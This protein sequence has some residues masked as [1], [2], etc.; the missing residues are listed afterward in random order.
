M[1]GDNLALLKTEDDP[2]NAWGGS[3][4]ASG[5]DY[6][7][8][9]EPETL[10]QK[11]VQKIRQWRVERMALD[12]RARLNWFTYYSLDNGRAAWQDN[13]YP[14]G[15]LGEKV[16]LRSGLVRNL[17]QHV[18]V[19][20][21]S[22]K[23]SIIPQAKNSDS[24]STKQVT[25]GKSIG[26][27]VMESYGG[28]AAANKATEYAEVLDQGFVEGEWDYEAGDVYAIGD[29]GEQVHEG[30]HRF[31]VLSPLDLFFDLAQVSWDDHSY[32]GVRKWRNRFDLIAKYC[33]GVAL[34]EVGPLADLKTALLHAPRKVFAE[35]TRVY[36]LP[37]PVQ[38]ESADTE[39]VEVFTF[40][41]KRSPAMPHGRR[42]VFLSTGQ[43]LEDGPLMEQK[44]PVWPVFPP[45]VI[46]TS[47]SFS[48]VTSLGSVQEAFNKMISM[49]ATTLFTHGVSNIGVAKGAN[50]DAT[51]VGGGQR[52]YE[53]DVGPGQGIKD[54]LAPIQ[55]T[56]LPK[57]VLEFAQIL[58]GIAEQ[59]AGLNK[60]VRGDPGGITAGVALSLYQAM[61]QQF[62][63]PLEDGRAEL[64]K[65]MVLWSW[66]ALRVYS[67]DMRRWVQVV[68]R[69]K[70]EALEKYFGSDMEG[71]DRLTVDLGNP[72]SRTAPG[73]VQ[74]IQM[75][76]QDGQ[77]L[78][79]QT[80]MDVLNTGTTDVAEEPD[81]E[82]M[83]LIRE[84]NA[85]LLD[86]LEPNVCL[87]QDDA[88]HIFHHVQMSFSTDLKSPKAMMRK[89]AT[90]AHL[91]AHLVKMSQGDLILLARRGMMQQGFAH[92]MFDHG[93]SP[94][95]PGGQKPPPPKG[96]AGVPDALRE[97]GRPAPN[98]VEPQPLSGPSPQQ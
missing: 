80:I 60:V 95:G 14:E 70:R 78:P 79:P 75:L 64:I 2:A 71:L 58:N 1:P 92:P 56:D 76:K 12:A 36:E 88:L 30:R 46:G 11:L 89:N 16:R 44:I 10:A 40:Y 45:N 33:P 35:D 67:P 72:L 48:T 26:Q 39:L 23:P 43:F 37:S 49:A 17:V 97:A 34:G 63:G 6:Y 9:E 69:G 73:R 29:G 15:E 5:A 84:E 52:V 47:F 13:L 85:M 25:I 59:D 20:T 18:L 50:I 21:N 62:Q 41:H 8:A 65:C 61:A 96:A 42:I 68:G 32:I 27:E 51:D 55:L 57:E 86:G 3:Y 4:P 74:I 98:P 93:A 31:N 90:E 54:V 28:Y 87:G 22:V 53:V 77:P 82:E 83:D 24:D 66:E 94:G 19:N 38:F 81:E 7:W 91:R